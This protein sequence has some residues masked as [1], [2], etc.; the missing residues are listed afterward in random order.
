MNSTFKSLLFWLAIVVAAIAIYQYSSLQAS[1]TPYSFTTFLDKVE[2]KEI[3]E[4]TF[5]GNKITG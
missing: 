3:A 1:D 5:T 2:L 4:V